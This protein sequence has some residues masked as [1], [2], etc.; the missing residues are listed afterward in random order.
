MRIARSSKRISVFALSGMLT[1]ILTA[2]IM[3]TINV[4]AATTPWNPPQPVVSMS[5]G[6]EH[7]CTISDEKVHCWGSNSEGQIGN[8]GTLQSAIP[9]ITAV[10]TSGV[11]NGKS[12]ISVTAG[13]RSTCAIDSNNDLY[14]WGDNSSGQLGDGTT[15]NRSSP[16][17]IGGALTG[18]KVTNVSISNYKVSYD[19]LDSDTTCAVADDKAYCWGSNSFGKIGDGTVQ[20]RLEPVAVSTSGVLA[21]KNINQ[22]ATSRSHTCVLTDEG[23]IACW[24][25]NRRGE[26]GNNTNNFSLSPASVNTTGVLM[27]KLVT[28]ISVG[29]ENTCAV[30]S[31]GAYCW[32]AND[33]G[34]LGDSTTVDRVVPSAVFTSGG[35]L[36]GK[37]ITKL[38]SGPDHSCVVIEDKSLYCWGGNS[39]GQLTGIGEY[40]YAPRS[41]SFNFHELASVDTITTGYS[42]TCASSASNSYCWGSNAYSKLG[43]GRSSEYMQMSNEPVDIVRNIPEIYMVSPSTLEVNGDD[44]EVTIE[45]T[46]ISNKAIVIIDGVEY[47]SNSDEGEH[48]GTSIT[49]TLPARVVALTKTVDVTIINPDGG[50][51]TASQSLSF[52]LITPS[53]SLIQPAKIEITKGKTETIYIYSNENNFMPSATVLVGNIQATVVSNQQS[54]IQAT[55]SVP[56]HITESG[57]WDVKVTNPNGAEVTLSNAIDYDVLVPNITSITPS[58]GYVGS[59]NIVFIQGTGIVRYDWMTPKLYVGGDEATFHGYQF[60]NPNDSSVIA[61]A[62]QLSPESDLGKADVILENS[63]G[64]RQT[65]ADGY[66]FMPIPEKKILS[67]NFT[68]M[69]EGKALAISG[70]ALVGMTNPSEYADATVRSLVTLNGT[71]LPFC[72]E[73]T[74]A[75][76]SEYIEL[77]GISTELVSDSSPCYVLFNPA[78]GALISTTRATIRLPDDFDITAQG[79]V[80]VNGSNTFTFNQQTTPNNEVA[81]PTVIVGNKS[82]ETKP[83]INK[84]PTFSGTA[85]PGAT[86]TV[87]VRSDPITCTTTADSNGNWSCTLPSELPPGDHTVTVRVVNPD[88]SVVELGPYAV[89]V[90]G[91]GAGVVTPATPLAPNT[92]EGRMLGLQ[93]NHISYSVVGLSIVFALVALVTHIKQSQSAK[94]LRRTSLML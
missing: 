45:G 56:D 27:G 18:K 88:N 69:G 92:G 14:C 72:T 59:N 85:E 47:H 25:R 89:V 57:K 65:I 4:N 71:E 82:L 29:E 67:T 34:Q 66:T 1:A 2:F 28:Q 90:T 83:T 31:G 19:D 12:I 11:L 43:N 5:A 46:G 63:D 79:T 80:S 77:Y 74:G 60:P 16:V 78:E 42:F 68:N 55:F 35:W 91:S 7:A 26:I 37:T 3:I 75:L 13:K 62:F 10:D 33:V 39:S 30:A 81:D 87:T 54:Y 24:G 52:N 20:A 94:R 44:H 61:Y 8:G 73:G 51:V 53:I 32:G 23:Q 64:F 40:P 15:I 38:S 36:G 58:S 70:E 50:S 21:G 93:N 76:A 48:I 9:Y 22:I 6:G 84:R 86:V 17:K 49:V 41:L